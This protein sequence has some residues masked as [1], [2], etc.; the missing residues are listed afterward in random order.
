MQ[1]TQTVKVFLSTKQKRVDNFD[2]Q[3]FANK[4]RSYVKTM[5]LAIERTEN[6]SNTIQRCM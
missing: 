1:D 3:A 2:V 4:A 6:L 5:T